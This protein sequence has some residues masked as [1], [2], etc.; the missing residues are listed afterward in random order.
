MRDI[1]I[2]MVLTQTSDNILFQISA[3]KV[4]AKSMYSNFNKG[5]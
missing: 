3:P 1:Y 4:P 5:T 2:S